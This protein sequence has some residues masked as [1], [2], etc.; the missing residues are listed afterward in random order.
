MKK[1]T[2][3]VLALVLL[4]SC[5]T[6]PPNPVVVEEPEPEPEPITLT[7]SVD[8]LPA[9]ID[10][11]STGFGTVSPVY[12]ACYEGLF[13]YDSVTGDLIPAI[14]DSY[15]VS[16]DGLTYT[17]TLRS[18]AKYSN[19]DNITA[20]DFVESFYKILDEEGDPFVRERLI[21]IISG[22]DDYVLPEDEQPEEFTLSDV[23]IY[24]NGNYELEIILSKPYSEFVA[25]LTM[26]AFAPTYRGSNLPEQDPESEELQPIHVSSGPFVIASESSTEFVAIRNTSYYNMLE[27]TVEQLY[28]SNEFLDESLGFANGDINII[29]NP[30]QNIYTAFPGQLVEIASFN[31]VY[32]SYNTR[33]SPTS[34]LLVRQ[35]ISLAIDRNGLLDENLPEQ[36]I[37]ASG[38]VAPGYIYSGN[39]FSDTLERNNFNLNDSIDESQQ[40]LSSARFNDGVGLNITMIVRDSDPYITYYEELANSVRQ[41]TRGE[42]S[43]VAMSDREY[44]EALESGSYNVAVGATLA[45]VLHPAEPL[46]LLHSENIDNITG[47]DDNAYDELLFEAAMNPTGMHNKEALQSA[48]THLMANMPVAP[49][50][51]PVHR[52]LINDQTEGCIVNALGNL[53]VTNAYVAQEDTQYQVD[54]I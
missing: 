20:D 11:L 27:V 7:V 40:A 9:K 2:S 29:L 16:E 1:I 24:S 15:N 52:M 8:E 30:E 13:S 51:H 4:A 44:E 54:G 33:R 14:C 32:L 10:P 38:L 21:E 45:D 19:G 42:I 36:G 50:F 49:L 35:A 25:M 17:F 18:N 53:Y 31:T 3:L 6:T 48:E 12:T 34:T 28:F 39:D 26:P 22:A 46:S 37:P 43:F 41:I 5:G 23:G 47:Y